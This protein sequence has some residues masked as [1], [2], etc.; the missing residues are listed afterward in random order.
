MKRARHTCK[1]ATAA[2][3]LMCTPWASGG[4]CCTQG[5]TRGEQEK[6][7]QLTRPVQGGSAADCTIWGSG[8]IMQGAEHATSTAWWLSAACRCSAHP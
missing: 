4:Q 8:R 3:Q 2:P 6:G 5:G 7:G 1:Q